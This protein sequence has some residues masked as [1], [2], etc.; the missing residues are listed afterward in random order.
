VGSV[1]CCRRDLFLLGD[2]DTSPKD[3]IDTSSKHSFVSPYLVELANEGA[4]VSRMFLDDMVLCRRVDP[5]ELLLP[6]VG[7]LTSSRHSL[8]M[9]ICLLEEPETPPND[10]MVISSKHSSVILDGIDLWCRSRLLLLEPVETSPREGIVISSRHSLGIPND[11]DG[12][13]DVLPLEESVTAPK[14]G[15]VISCRHSLVMGPLEKLAYIG[16]DISLMFCVDID[17]LSWR[18]LRFGDK[19]DT[20][21]YEGMVISSRH[22]LVV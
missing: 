1:I 10:G 5:L 13:L 9:V 6:K 19:P 12:L 17:F 4:D 7:A 3:G 8:G 18:R 11:E 20:L 16:S 22:S 21:P 2:L 14:D 15:M